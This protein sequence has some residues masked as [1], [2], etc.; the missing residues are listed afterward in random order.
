MHQ[1]LKENK[2]SNSPSKKF[3]YEDVN[4]QRRNEEVTKK[5]APTKSELS[6]FFKITKE[7]IA[8]IY[9]TIFTITLKKRRLAASNPG[10]CSWYSIKILQG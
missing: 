7:Q 9:T 2:L 3:L 1:F 10:K 5:I 6:K 4:N 8:L